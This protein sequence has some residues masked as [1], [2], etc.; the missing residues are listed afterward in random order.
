MDEPCPSC[1]GGASTSCSLD[2]DDSKRPCLC[3]DA[4]T[5]CAID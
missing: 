3:G 5:E 2:G 1:G 4:P